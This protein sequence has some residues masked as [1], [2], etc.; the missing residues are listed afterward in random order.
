MGKM[1]LRIKASDLYRYDGTIDRAPYF[2]LGASLMSVKYL[3]DMSVSQMIFHRPWSFIDYF[4]PALTL[5]STGI[6]TPDFRFYSTMLLISLPFVFS[7][8]VL[9]IRRLRATELPLWM[10]IW[11]FFPIINLVFFK[12]LTWLPSQRDDDEYDLIKTSRSL[13]EDS[14]KDEGG[15]FAAKVSKPAEFKKGELSREPQTVVESLRSRRADTAI[16]EFLDKVI[17]ENKWYTI[18]VASALPVP[19]AVVFVYAAAAILGNYGWSLFI[20]APF[21]VSIIAP[22]LYGYKKRRTSFQCVKASFLA[23]FLTGLGAILF[24][25]EGIVCLIMAFPLIAFVAMIGGSIAYRIQGPV[26]KDEVPRITGSLALLLPLMTM[27]EI[28]SPSTPPV[29][30]VSTAVSVD[31]GPSAVWNRVVCFPPMKA[32]DDLIF[33]AGIAYPTHATINGT[34]YGAIRRCVFNTGTFV[35]PIT[36]YDAPR[37][38]KFD[39]TSQARP[40]NETSIYADLHPPH[41]NGYMMSKMGQFLLRKT[42]D[43]GTELEGTTWYQNRMEPYFYWRILSD[44]IIH[45]IHERVL[46]HVKTVSENDIAKAND[47][48]KLTAETT[49]GAGR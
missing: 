26:I 3:L 12:V 6:A 5:T 25:I 7:G 23:L 9:T 48:R 29:Y 45:K 42:S 30:K 40:M 21:A 32:P 8:A 41:L 31:A 16:R 43:A 46:V 18:F 4:A 44:A 15:V 36:V 19:F 10:V 13:I 2:I 38:L 14:S 20:A 17:P 28:S 34:G 39:V 22:I 1:A 49:Q 37:L 27:W 33:K 24:H 11:F 35:E 47:R